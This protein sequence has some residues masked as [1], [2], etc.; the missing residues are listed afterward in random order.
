MK[1]IQEIINQILQ[2]LEAIIFEV[3]QIRD[4]I[5]KESYTIEIKDSS[6]KV[7]KTVKIN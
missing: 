6:G 4:N 5:E 2:K 3:E 7:I 1:D